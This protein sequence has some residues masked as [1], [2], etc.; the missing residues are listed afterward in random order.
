MTWRDISSAP[1]D[2]TPVFAG[3]QSKWMKFLYIPY[4]MMWRW[5]GG[6]WVGAE[7]ERPYEPQP[8]HWLPA[9]PE[10]ENGQ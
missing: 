5:I 4:P 3:A 7:D 1:K 10:Q 6:Q 9:P 2:G 8:T